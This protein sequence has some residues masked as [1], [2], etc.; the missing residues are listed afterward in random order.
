MH[1]TTALY[2][3]FQFH[4]NIIFLIHL[5]ADVM[6]FGPMGRGQRNM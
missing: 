4:A 3:Q 6:I 5:T 2:D 1:Y